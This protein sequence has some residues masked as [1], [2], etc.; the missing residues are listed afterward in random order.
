MSSI[1]T[2]PS[3]P[4]AMLII[5]QGGDPESIGVEYDS[6][7]TDR[8]ERLFAL[9][10][11]IVDRIRDGHGSDPLIAM[12]LF[13]EL[14]SFPSMPDDEDHARA[15]DIITGLFHNP[16]EIE[17]IPGNVIEVI[18]DVVVNIGIVRSLIL[19]YELDLSA[20]DDFVKW[21]MCYRTY[22]IL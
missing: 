13:R 6:L 4:E 22:M 10:Q 20:S 12:M 8:Y 17:D 15:Q 11:E 3:N 7:S 5:M 14:R 1:T 18:E 2:T 21:M 16:R 19:G 9:R